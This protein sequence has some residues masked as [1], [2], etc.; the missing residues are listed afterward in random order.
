MGMNSIGS[1]REPRLLCQGVCSLF[2]VSGKSP[3]DFKHR[4][5]SEN[6][7]TCSGEGLSEKEGRQ[8]RWNSPSQRGEGNEE[9]LKS[10]SVAL[11][12]GLPCLGTPTS[13]S[14]GQ[15]VPR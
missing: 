2:F 5:G 1:I 10:F 15:P 14:K 8:E 13:F 4:S 9:I 3:W 7:L 11:P 6:A 12:L